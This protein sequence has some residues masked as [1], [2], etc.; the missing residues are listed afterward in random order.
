MRSDRRTR[1]TLCTRLGSARLGLSILRESRSVILL[2]HSPTIIISNRQQ[3]QRAEA[4]GRDVG[5]GGNKMQLVREKI[6][7]VVVRAPAPVKAT[8]GHTH[9]HTHTCTHTYVYSTTHTHMHT[10]TPVC[11]VYTAIICV[12]KKPRTVSAPPL[13][14]SLS[15]SLSLFRSPL[16]FIFDVSSP[17]LN[18]LSP[19]IHPA[20]FLLLQAYRLTHAHAH[21][22]ILYSCL[23][24]CVCGLSYDLKD[25]GY[26][27]GVWIMNS[28]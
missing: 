21:A 10:C 17:Q 4:A 11:S 28:S 23:C 24:V 3:R 6:D 1:P 19:C 27:F 9:I 5:S 15:L 8:V 22:H 12:I 13:A 14:C 18:H 16:S 25:I 2:R 26:R 7:D 20:R